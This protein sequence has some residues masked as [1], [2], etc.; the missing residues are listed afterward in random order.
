MANHKS[1]VKRNKQTIKKTARNKAIK[2][3]LKNNV[4][5]LRASIEGKEKDAATEQLKT[6][7]VKLDKAVTKNIMHKN[8]AARTVS[9]L[10][11]QVN[12]L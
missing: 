11:K 9:R 1:A 5:S 7:T 6:V 3:N 2:T 12:A 10:T 4:K 8:T